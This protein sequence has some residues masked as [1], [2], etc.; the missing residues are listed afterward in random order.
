MTQHILD[1]SGRSSIE[2]PTLSFLSPSLREALEELYPITFLE[3]SDANYGIGLGGRLEFFGTD[4]DRSRGLK[5]GCHRLA[6]DVRGPI[7]TSQTS[8][9][10]LKFAD[11]NALD[12]AFR[13]RRLRIKPYTAVRPV[14]KSAG[15]RILA[16]YDDVPI[17]AYREELD[18]GIDTVSISLPTIADNESP[19]DYFNGDNFITLLPL[20]Q[21]LRR[22]TASKGWQLPCPR[23]CFMF[24]DPNLHWP[25]YGYVN[26]RELA[27]RAEHLRYHVAFAMVPLDSW[28]THSRAARVFSDN[29]SRLSLLLHGNDH[30]RAELAR[31]LS[32]EL[33]LAVAAQALR[34]ADR[35]SRRVGVPVARAMAA[36]HGA[37]RNAMML[38]M[39]LVGI[40]GAFISPWS[41]RL[42][43]SDRQWSSAFGLR[44]AEIVHQ[45]FPVAPRFR[46]STDSEGY[47]I[48]SA[49][50]GRPIV[51]TGHHQSLR[52][53]IDILDEVAKSVNSLPGVHWSNISTILR[54][55]YTYK[56]DGDLLRVQPF[57]SHFEVHIPEDIRQLRIEPT[58]GMSSAL[59]SVFAPFLFR[60]K[61]PVSDPWCALSNHDT[62]PVIERST[63]EVR[64]HQLGSIDPLAVGSPPFSFFA[65]WRRIAC[66]ARDRLLPL[67]DRIRPR[68]QNSDVSGGSRNSPRLW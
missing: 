30:L 26:F 11:D 48:L 42:W 50:L 37:C 53:G 24:D 29:S 4:S 44:P 33:S 52:D 43:E 23:A 18:C 58:T 16:W 1:Q 34:R 14:P 36:P 40:E 63:V 19:F 17:W 13:N 28:Y 25:T 20:F 38:A 5:P 55:Q 46:L 3:A 9:P 67:V 51:P 59:D 49:F 2:L 6:I 7:V 47:I 61:K 32:S 39:L 57:S 31:R 45:A 54:S 27:S 65:P 35:F 66:E 21:F 12:L 41:L 8:S 62:I 56:R 68:L 10:C 15:H 64:H 22:I 60:T